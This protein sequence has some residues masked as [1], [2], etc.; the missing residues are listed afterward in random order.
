MQKE[1]RKNA[2]ITEENEYDEE[3]VD[4]HF[5]KQNQEKEGDIRWQAYIFQFFNNKKPPK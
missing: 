5:W 4:T 3:D 1:E 2:T